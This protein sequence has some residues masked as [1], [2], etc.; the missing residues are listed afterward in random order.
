MKIL[1]VTNRF[2]PS[3]GGVETHVLE[4][5]KRFVNAG[6]EV[7]VLSSDFK[8]LN[9]GEKYTD[10]EKKGKI[11]GI[12]FIRFWSF[13]VFGI[14][15]STFPLFLFFWL[16]LNIRKYD[17]VHSHTYGYV[18]GWMPILVGKMFGVKTVFT[19]HLSNEVG[20][21][22]VL[23]KMY[24]LFI[25]SW[26]LKIVDKIIALTKIEKD[27]LIE[28]Y[29]VK[30]SKLEIIP[31]G[32]N[33]SEFSESD[34][35]SKKDLLEKYNIK[36]TNKVLINVARIAKTKGQIFLL[37]AFEEIEKEN[38]DISL[39]I[40][41]KDWGEQENLLCY[42]QEKNIN[43]FYILNNVNDLDK[44]NFLRISDLFVLPSFASEAF[45]IVLLEAM[46]S[47][48]PVVGTITGGVPDV[49]NSQVGSLAKHSDVLCL[50]EKILYELSINRNKE[51]IYNYVKSYDWS[52]IANKI[53]EIYNNKIK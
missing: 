25:T 9:G 37:K 22:L 42:A 43:S 46:Q 20:V 27:L 34:F 53:L 48:L 21:P 31:N 36:N 4:I 8:E 39:I 19:P 12:K 47:K 30:E 14:D 49:I 33:L 23:R 17:V 1:Q 13:R 6:Y 45:G 24:D 2:Y 7:V 44:N 26:Q 5:S 11:F 16:I 3:L 52:I 32:I 18:V 29:F 41:G 28:K 35:V 10:E 40:I 38:K 15:A 50:K 51:V